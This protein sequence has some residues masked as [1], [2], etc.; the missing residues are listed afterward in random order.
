MSEIVV[1]TREQWR[2][3]WLTC[4]S[5]RNPDAD[6]GPGSYP[7]LRASV[8]ADSMVILSNDALAISDS[9]PLDNMTGGQLDAKYGSK[10]PRNLET[11]ASGLVSFSAGSA[12][13]LLYVGDRLSHAATKNL[14]E[15][16]SATDTYYNTGKLVV[17]SV[18]PGAGQN[19]SPGEV[20]QWESPRAGS[21]ATVTV[22]ATQDGNGII[23]GRSV[24]SD[25][26]YRERIRDY[27]ANPVGHG[28]EGDVATLI[29]D[30]SKHGV[31]V[32]KAFLYPAVFG[33]GSVGY[34]FTVKT[35]NYW[36]YRG[37][38]A[39]QLSAVYNHVVAN[40]PGDFSVTSGSL[41]PSSVYLALNV[42]LDPRVARWADSV[43]WPTYVARGS[44]QRVVTA[45]TSETVF[46]VGTDSGLY[47]GV[48]PPSAGNT[49]GLFDATTGV[50][51]R[52]KILTVAGAGPWDIV[53]DTTADQTDVSFLPLVTQAISPW[54]DAINECAAA[55]GKHCAKLGPGEAVSAVSIPE[56]GTRMRRQPM[57]FQDQFDNVVNSD[58]AYNVHRSVG[59]VATCVYLSPIQTTPTGSAAFL[60][61]IK[62]ADLAIYKA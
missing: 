61:L 56:D 59:A 17:A 42:T 40:L 15:L 11:K 33:P 46:S 6:I 10:L 30:S 32:E 16:K 55:A 47:S 60:R 21:Y 24:E 29:E 28:N 54:F 25:D 50:F 51:K 34:T 57:P 31:P 23:G 13:A 27:N 9:I 41:V 22:F 18:D 35:D 4:Y 53:C 62:M 5:N 45:V 8:F 14:Y 26:E 48:I 44:G 58:I 39:A 36:D 49:I 7:W 1:N 38:T 37:P 2:D 43:P 12:G 52:K 19:L 20:L 3:Y